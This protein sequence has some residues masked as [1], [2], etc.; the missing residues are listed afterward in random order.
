MQSDDYDAV[1]DCVKADCDVKA[2]VEIPNVFTANEDNRNDA[3]KILL[4]HGSIL[5][6]INVYNR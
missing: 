2:Q 6:K 3:F 1:H 4:P 5:K